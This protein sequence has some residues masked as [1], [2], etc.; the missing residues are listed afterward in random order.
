MGRD[1]AATHNIKNNTYEKVG[2]NPANS[3]QTKNRAQSETT[4]GTASATTNV[5]QNRCK[6]NVSQI[7]CTL[8]LGGSR[9]TAQNKRVAEPVRNLQNHARDPVFTEQTLQQKRVSDPVQSLT[10][11]AVGRDPLLP[12]PQPTASVPSDGL[13][14]VRP[15][16]A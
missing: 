7:R 1:P 8:G 10:Q 5:S 14:K 3:T 6:T 2:R 15:A 12:D 16:E 13:Q 9:P 4:N 11:M